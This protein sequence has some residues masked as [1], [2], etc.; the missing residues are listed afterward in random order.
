MRHILCAG[1]WFNDELKYIHQPKNIE[2]GFVIAGRM[3]H[4]CFLTLSMMLK[5]VGDFKSHEQG[6]I[7]SDDMFVNRKE[8]AKIAFAAGQTKK[9]KSLL[10]SDDLY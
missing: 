4:N 2:T 7:T 3:H 1:I 5:R 6:F 9:L 10:F 8:A